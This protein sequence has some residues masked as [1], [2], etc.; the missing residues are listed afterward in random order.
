MQVITDDNVR[1]HV[2]DVGSGSPVVF[3]HEF[4]GDHRSFEPQM[5]FFSRAHR[6][7]TF[8]ARGYL[9]SDVPED[10]A[11]YGQ[12]RARA[13][14]IAVMDGLG[15]DRAHVVGH[16]MGAYT[17]LHVGLFHPERCLSVAALGCGWG[18]N[19]AERDASIIAC[20][21]IADMFRSEPIA[22]AAAK[23]ARAP[24]RLTFEAKD[25]RGFAEFERMLAEHSGLGSALTMLNLQIKRPTLWEL[26]ADLKA[27]EP[28]LLVIVGDEDFPCIEGSVFLKRVVPTAGLLMLPRAG[29]TITSEEPA[30]VNAALGE[31]FAAAEAGTW[32]SH[33]NRGGGA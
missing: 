30:A 2:E 25:P 22:E 32:M 10:P 29:H 17:A 23:Y 15:I 24:M 4:A 13:D 9:P 8:A 14:V 5:R 1:L 7:V 16:S 12:D 31:L 33:R 20:E 6:C 27:F 21:A 11:A 26:E 3:V 18:S 19:P 28:P